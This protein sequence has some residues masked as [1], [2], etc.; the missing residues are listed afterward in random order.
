MQLLLGP[1]RQ[2]YNVCPAS[3]SSEIFPCVMV[4]VYF[5]P[6]RSDLIGV[7]PLLASFLCLPILLRYSTLICFIC[8]LPEVCSYVLLSKEHLDVPLPAQL[9]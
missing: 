5:K 2:G 7:N 1:E 6:N 9:C 4:K 3:S 8:P